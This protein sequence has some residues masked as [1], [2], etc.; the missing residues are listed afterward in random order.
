M[1]NKPLSAGSASC[2]WTDARELSHL[3]AAPFWLN[4]RKEQTQQREKECG[5]NNLS[6]CSK[7]TRQMRGEADSRAVETSGLPTWWW[8]PLGELLVDAA[9]K[10]LLR[11]SLAKYSEDRPPFLKTASPSL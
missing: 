8:K 3:S 7:H 6:E 10:L 11:M 4:P 5:G 1:G 2:L 9:V